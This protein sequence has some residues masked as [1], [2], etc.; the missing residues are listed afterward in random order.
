LRLL[1]V[2]FGSKADICSAQADV[3]F[4]P[5]AD[6]QSGR[7]ASIDGE[8]PADNAIVT[9]ASAGG[10][11]ESDASMAGTSTTV[12]AD[13]HRPIPA[14]TGRYRGCD[15]LA[16]AKHHVSAVRRRLHP[17]SPCTSLVLASHRHILCNGTR[18][19][20]T[21]HEASVIEAV[22]ASHVI[23][24]LLSECGERGTIGIARFDPYNRSAKG[25]KQSK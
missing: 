24:V 2:R 8:I 20:S 4:V 12:A 5:I 25:S 15:G 19:P 7:V 13:L 18:R 9:A 11:S 3:R 22:A 21:L 1:Y 14:A 6:V 23:G 16:P 17:H 10:S